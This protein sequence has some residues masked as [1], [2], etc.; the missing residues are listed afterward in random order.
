MSTSL[1]KTESDEE[2]KLYELDG[3]LADSDSSSQDGQ[4]AHV[5]NSDR[6]E[7]KVEL[8][9][10]GEGTVSTRFLLLLTCSFFG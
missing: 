4:Q 3:L 1:S 10:L 2:A 9:S 8:G 5:E 6:L 7:E